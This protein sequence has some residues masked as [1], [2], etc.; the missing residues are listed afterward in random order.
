[1]EIITIGLDCKLA[2]VEVRERLSFPA[3][4][5]AEAF[6]NLADLPFA[7]EMAI[8]STCNRVELYV[9][10]EHLA[11]TD[12]FAELRRFLSNFH[13]VEESLF[14]PYLYYISGQPA[15]QHLFEVASGL[16]S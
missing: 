10:S 8:L 6:Q 1:M 15:V 16:Q 4:R 9:V 13:G 5:L 7:G 2:P 11:Q 12:T 3:N 14:S